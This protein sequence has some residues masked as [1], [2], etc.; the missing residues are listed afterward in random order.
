MSFVYS[1]AK[2][3]VVLASLLAT[4]VHG[5]V[6]LSPATSSSGA[7]T[8]SPIISPSYTGFGIEPS[9]VMAYTGTTTVNQLTY[10]LM[11]NLANFTGAP[12][13]LRIGGNAGDTMLYSSTVTGYALQ[14]NPNSNGAGNALAS[15]YYYFGPNYFKAIG[16]LPPGTP[17]TYGLNLAYT[18]TNAVQQMVNQAQ[19]AF[20]NIGDSVNIVGLEIGNEPDLYIDLGY[21]QSGWS[22]TDFGTEWST[23]AQAVYQQV[24]QPRNLSSAF[25]E[26]ATTATTAA[27]SGQPYRISNLVTTGVAIDNGIYVAGWNQH[28]YYYYVNVSSYELTLSTLLDLSTTV[29]QFNEWK[30]QAQQAIV[31]GKPYYLR[32]MGSVGPNGIPG[33]SD[34]FG[35]AL[36]TLNFFF[37]AATV[38][39][40]GVQMHM[41]QYSEGSPWQP[42][43]LNGQGPHVRPSYY[44]WA[45]FNSVIGASCN[46]KIAQVNLNNV[47]ASYTNRLNAYS[48]YRGDSLAA[49]ALINTQLSY[50]SNGGYANYQNF[51]LSLPA[52][53]GQTIYLAVMTA[54][55]VDSLAGATYNGVSYERSGNGSPTLV[56]S[57]SWT[58]TVG[59]DGTLTVPVRD[60]QAVIAS[61]MRLG[62]ETV[63]TNNCAALASSTTEGGGTASGA[64]GAS[65]APTFKSTT[66]FRSDQ[67]LSL[68]AIIGIAA[69]GGVFLLIVLGLLIWCCVAS[70]RK[71]KNR[72]R[73]ARLS[74]MS[75]AMPPVGH[76]NTRSPDNQALLARDHLRQQHEDHSLSYPTY[77][78]P[79]SGGGSPHVRGWDSPMTSVSHGHLITP[80]PPRMHQP[81]FDI[82]RTPPRQHPAML[83]NPYAQPQPHY[84]NGGRAY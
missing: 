21:R 48:V 30:Q 62:Q 43:T 39:V 17:I 8:L 19:A 33:I 61:T 11:Q 53:A 80:Q 83:P 40:S 71:R 56:N 73:R 70:S 1:L 79:V 55:G 38:Q 69:G 52:L 49:L 47:P 9:N 20:D 29:N 81:E 16:Q 77:G 45:A 74:A 46:S 59:S 26:P 31:T 27:K 4:S 24:L 67:V 14:N 72:R 60:S 44:A 32:E 35:N 5:D 82:P 18:G 28:D 15:D 37:Y 57:T 34:T 23:R 65:A 75:A 54:P 50:S 84:D 3:V 7:G 6:N 42:I 25:F 13:H 22:V 2:G 68:G 10:N 36:W 66:G 58:M 64:G 51:V 78:P 12:P 76:H 63:D 41:T